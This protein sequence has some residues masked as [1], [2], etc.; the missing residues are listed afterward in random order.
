MVEGMVQ[1][2]EPN[3]YKMVD[4]KVKKNRNPISAEVIKV[5]TELRLD[6]GY[7]QKQVA[8]MTNTNLRTYANFERGVS[9]MKV[10]S[11]IKFLQVYDID[12]SKLILDEYNKTYAEK[13]RELEIQRELERERELDEPYERT[14]DYSKLESIINNNDMTTN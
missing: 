12:L 13:Q 9:D 8:E 5:L 6:S 3:I 11:L 14:H 1:K 10:S 4:N 7:T 2:D